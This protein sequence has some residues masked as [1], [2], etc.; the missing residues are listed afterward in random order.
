MKLKLRLSGLSC[1]GCVNA[2]R[3][4]LENAG[5]RVLRID[6][7]S[8]EIEIPEDEVL[9]KFLKVIREAGYSAEV[10]E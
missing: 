8:A 9:E 4:S 6:L 7:K 3:A 5:A 2:V 1:M 10:E